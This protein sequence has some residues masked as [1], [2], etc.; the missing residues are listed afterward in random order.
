V[1]G[2]LVIAKGAVPR[3]EASAL[4]SRSEPQKVKLLTSGRMKKAD[5][6]RIISCTYDRISKKHLTQ[7]AQHQLTG[8]EEDW[9]AP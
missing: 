6:G 9:L 8:D 4:A 1:V 7:H 3:L 2:V 5:D